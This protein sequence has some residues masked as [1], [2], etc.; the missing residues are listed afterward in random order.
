MKTKTTYT[1]TTNSSLVT[2]ETKEIIDGFG[3]PIQTIKVN[4]TPNSKDVIFAKAYDNNGRLWKEYLPFES[5]GNTG[6]YMPI[7]SGTKFKETL[8]EANPLNRVSSVTPPGWYA[9]TYSY[10]A[11]TSTD[12]LNPMTGSNY[13]ANLLTKVVVTDPMNNRSIEYKDKLGRQVMTWKTDDTY[14]NHAKTYTVYDNKDRVSK[15]IPPGAVMGNTD[16]IYA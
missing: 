4:H 12:V 14:T 1:A 8:Y 15:V 13:A 7:P 6:A 5:S 3:R 10:G 2:R 16:L 11:N 9:T